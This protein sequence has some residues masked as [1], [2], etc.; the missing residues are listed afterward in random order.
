MPF[1]I[2]HQDI[3]KMNTDAI[4][5]AAN[6]GLQCGGGVCGAIFT[7]AGARKLEKACRQIGYCPTGSAVITP[8]F[9]LQAKYV[10]HAVGPFWQGGQCGERERL[11]DAY[12]KS[13]E[14]AAEHKLSS[15]AFPL[16]S[17]GIY[18]YPKAE[19]LQVAIGVFAEFLADHE[20]DIYLAVFDRKAVSLSENLF[21][22]ITHYIDTYYVEKPQRRRLE[23]RSFCMASMK[24][25]QCAM[26]L[27]S[28]AGD[29]KSAKESNMPE[30]PQFLTRKKKDRD[31]TE[32]VN[33]LGETFSEMV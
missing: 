1:Q 27:P 10:I 17:S 2:V 24:M 32:V 23:E 14:L 20:M 16:I 28:M 18:G 12:R 25:P 29:A 4:V 8:G 22:N 11:A 9:D 7:A 13:L 26:E 31:L 30:I 19:A 5:N 6:S 3:T 33:N 15:I 21:A